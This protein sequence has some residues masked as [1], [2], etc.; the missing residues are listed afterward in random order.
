MTRDN[1]ANA[2]ERHLRNIVVGDPRIFFALQQHLEAPTTRPAE[3]VHLCVPYSTHIEQ[4]EPEEWELST[5]LCYTIHL[6]NVQ[7][8][9]VE[10]MEPV[11][12]RIVLMP[13]IVGGIQ[14]QPAQ[15]KKKAE[16]VLQSA[17]GGTVLV[18]DP[19][20]LSAIDQMTFAND[21]QLQG[22]MPLLFLGW[23]A[24]YAAYVGVLRETLFRLV[25]EHLAIQGNNLQRTQVQDSFPRDPP[26]PGSEGWKATC[27]WFCLYG[28]PRLGMSVERLA[29]TIAE[30]YSTTAKKVHVYRTE[31]N[32]PAHQNGRRN[33]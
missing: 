13:T 2:I 22:K 20:R 12:D 32:L 17:Q 23:Y 19:P 5:D 11:R 1:L 33:G 24:T 10:R 4:R 29:E 6:S 28:K 25:A 27:R 30:P 7:Y 18:A 15:Y 14:L 21:P 16:I 8:G 31:H 26:H 9:P 3:S